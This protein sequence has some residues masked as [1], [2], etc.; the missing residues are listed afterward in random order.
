[1]LMALSVHHDT[2]GSPGVEYV[3][4]GPVSIVNAGVFRSSGAVVQDDVRGAVPI[5][6]AHRD[7][8][9]PAAPG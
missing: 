5:Q 4:K 1:M 8:I 3:V 9:I 2:I 6:I 7:E